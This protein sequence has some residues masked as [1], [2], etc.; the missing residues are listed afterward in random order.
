MK[1]YGEWRYSSTILDFGTG[2][3]YG[4]FYVSATLRPTKG[5]GMYCIGGLVAPRAGLEAVDER[6]SL[7]AY[8]NRTLAIQPVARR[9]TD[10]IICGVL[11]SKPILAKEGKVADRVRIPRHT[12]HWRA[13]VNTVMNP[14]LCTRR[15]FLISSATTSFS[16][17]L[18]HGAHI[19]LTH[20]SQTSFACAMLESKFH[21]SIGLQQP[22]VL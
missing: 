12:V 9:Y 6:K 21:V 4:Q 22:I 3:K 20:S 7:A 5:H 19:L 2:W 15:K 8:G 17:I 13:V 1:T 14:G 11:I 18:L 16:S 10:W